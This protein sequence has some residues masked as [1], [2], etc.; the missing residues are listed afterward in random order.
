MSSYE[1]RKK[2]IREM[3]EELENIRKKYRVQYKAEIGI[4]NYS[5]ETKEYFASRK[6]FP[7]EI[8]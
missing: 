1:I 8:Y 6:R 5:C 3:Y 2:L 7:K 4:D